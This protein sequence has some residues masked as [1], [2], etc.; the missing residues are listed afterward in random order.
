MA[1]DANAT[2]ATVVD[3]LA[4]DTVFGVRPVPEPSVGVLLL[5]GVG[6]LIACRRPLRFTG[7]RR[8]SGP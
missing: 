8:T 3:T 4:L 6:V 2:T 7:T 1:S 5:A